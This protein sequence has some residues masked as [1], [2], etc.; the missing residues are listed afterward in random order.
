M[1]QSKQYKKI[2]IFSFAFLLCAVFAVPIKA[3]AAILTIE[4]KTDSVSVRD[5]VE[6]NVYLNTEGQSVNVV[7]GS[8]GY[9]LELLFLDDV[10]TQDSFIGFWI[11]EPKNTVDGK[12]QFS[13]MV[14]GGINDKKALLF[15]AVFEA[16]LAG[17]AEI[18]FSDAEALLNDGAGTRA[19][20]SAQPLI[21]DIAEQPKAVPAVVQEVLRDEE[22]PEAFEITIA[23][24]PNLFG[25]K[26]VAIFFTKDKKSG[27]D[28]YEIQEGEDP[29]VVATSPH[30]LKYQSSDTAVTVRAV[31][32]FG[33]S[34][35]AT[36]NGDD[37]GR[38]RVQGS[39]M[40]NVLLGIAGVVSAL[41]VFTALKRRKV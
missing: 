4:T 19:Q 25:G 8:L 2:I 16:V 14:P 21:I 28:H 17:S 35:T 34:R 9:P 10:R 40:L 36:V 37:G 23:R 20:F 3:S 11:E 22:R 1:D 39:R 24:D 5:R 32:A 18:T 33:N 41:Y 12:I 29:F 30:V 26:Y 38:S 31:D 13:G 7:G 6:M 27:V 15:S